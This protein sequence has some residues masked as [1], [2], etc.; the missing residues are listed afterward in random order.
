MW[1]FASGNRNSE[2]L[3][4]GGVV[5]NEAGEVI[6]EGDFLIPTSEVTQLD[7][8]FVNG[9][10]GT[11]SSSVKTENLHIPTHRFLSMPSV[12]MG[13]S[14]GLSAHDA[15]EWNVRLAPVPLLA[16]ALTGAAI[17]IARQALRDFPNLVRGKTIAYTADDQLDRKSTRLNSSHVSE[18]RMPSSA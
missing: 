18:S 3:L 9:L 11:G 14:P 6:D 5:K 15:D 8:W 17:G 4:L 1:P 7:D 2:W 16:I 10:T 13:T 12:V